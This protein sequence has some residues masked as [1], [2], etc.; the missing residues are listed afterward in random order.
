MGQK[1][2]AYNPQGAITAFYDSV[3]SPVPAE[4]NA[5]EITDAQ[6][7]TCINEQGQWYVAYDTLAQVL[8]P[9]AEQQLAT[10]QASQVATLREACAEA[11]MSG[12]SS[13]ALDSTYSYPSTITDQSNQQAIA[14]NANGG[15]LWCESGGAWSFKTHT[16][17]QAQAVV[18]SFATWL[19]KCQAQLVTLSGQIS[20]TTSVDSAQAVEWTNPTTA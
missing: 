9:S 14:S 3:D 16:Q 11:I 1:Y 8:P 10:A 12:F 17:A 19:N 20:A 15:S 6:W 18:A 7:Q 13:A 4:V 2:A 5:I